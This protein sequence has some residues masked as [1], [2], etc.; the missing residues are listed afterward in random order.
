MRSSTR[1]GG[2]TKG[3]AEAD[4][5]RKAF[6]DTEL[7]ALHEVPALAWREE[8]RLNLRVQLLNKHLWHVQG[9]GLI[10]NTCNNHHNLYLSRTTFG[11]QLEFGLLIVQWRNIHK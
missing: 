2:W 9:L 10:K 11:F 7:T 3:E 8:A 6:C 5:T 4:T 1:Q